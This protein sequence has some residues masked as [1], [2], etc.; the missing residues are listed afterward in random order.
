MCSWEGANV[1][2][3]FSTLFFIQNKLR[4]SITKNIDFTTARLHLTASFVRV[5]KD[6]FLLNWKRSKT[7]GVIFTNNLAT[8]VIVFGNIPIVGG[9]IAKVIGLITMNSDLFMRLL[10]SHRFFIT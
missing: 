2:E 9:F 10:F 5:V 1:V 4:M 6:F 8:L 7:F 3:G